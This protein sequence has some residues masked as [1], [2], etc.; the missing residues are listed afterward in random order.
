MAAPPRLPGPPVFHALHQRPAS[1]RRL[2]EVVPEAAR[3]THPGR[4]AL[5]DVEGVHQ[6]GPVG[7]R[8]RQAGGR[9]RSCRCR[10]RGGGL[11]ARSGCGQTSRSAWRGDI[12]Q[13][14]EHL[15]GGGQ[16]RD[17]EAPGAP[18][19]DAASR[20]SR[21]SPRD[22]T[23]YRP[24]ILPRGASGRRLR[25]ARTRPHGNCPG[26]AAPSVVDVSGLRISRVAVSACP[27]VPP[28]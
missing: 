5:N 3:L 6:D 12:R 4:P 21:K 23:T 15:A 18:R 11:A 1:P 13:G 9:P 7:I 14:G 10:P 26:G 28:V 24:C 19:N 25:P 22:P 16:Q 17:G 20:E 8:P 27:P 2:G